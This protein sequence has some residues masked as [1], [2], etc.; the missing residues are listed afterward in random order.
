MQKYW[1]LMAAAVGVIDSAL[2]E[3][4]GYSEILWVFSGRRGV[5]CW[6][7]FVQHGSGNCQVWVEIRKAT[8]WVLL[9]TPMAQATKKNAPA[10]LGQDRRATV[11]NAW[12]H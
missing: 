9:R 2:R 6:V 11:R 1:P 7:C 10:Q 8:N 3:D 12:P 4:F 5:H